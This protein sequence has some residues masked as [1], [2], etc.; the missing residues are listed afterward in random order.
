MTEADEGYGCC[1]GC[2]ASVPID[3]LSL[4][5]FIELTGFACEECK[6]ETV[7]VAH[8]AGQGGET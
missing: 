2:G 8:T 1:D 3:Q 7:V 6:R 4:V 5:T